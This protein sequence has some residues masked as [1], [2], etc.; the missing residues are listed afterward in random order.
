MAVRTPHGLAL[1]TIGF[2]IQHAAATTASFEL[3]LPMLTVIIKWC[4]CMCTFQ[5]NPINDHKV[6]RRNG[7][8]TQTR[9][10]SSTDD[11]GEIFHVSR[12]YL[13]RKNHWMTSKLFFAFLKILILVNFF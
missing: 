5:Y 12:R 6:V 8:A 4:V 9:I 11:R 3:E 13:A 7:A 10:A 1:T 2:I